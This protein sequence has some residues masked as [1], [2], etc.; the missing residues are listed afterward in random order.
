MELKSALF[1]ELNS[2]KMVRYHTKNA[3][4]CTMW[5]N[6]GIIKGTVNKWKSNL[7]PL[8][9]AAKAL[10]TKRIE[11]KKKTQLI[12]FKHFVLTSWF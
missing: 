8:V 1:Y 12:K 3:K 4:R 11:L 7:Q 5:I 2:Y 9:H 6:R 10:Q